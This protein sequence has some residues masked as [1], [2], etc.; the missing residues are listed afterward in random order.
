MDPVV[1]SVLTSIALSAAGSIVTWA[2]QGGF[3]AQDQAASL[4]TNLGAMIVGGVTAAIGA[5]L[6]WYKARQHTQAAMIQAVN[7]APNGV[8]VVADDA[9]SAPIASV[10]GPVK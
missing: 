2:V 6:V 4:T 8:K 5:A 9:R 7:A 1:K 3:V 10:S